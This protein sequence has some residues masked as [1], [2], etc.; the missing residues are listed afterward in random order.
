MDRNARSVIAGLQDTLG[1]AKI[2]FWISGASRNMP[3]I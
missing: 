3:M 1:I 2:V